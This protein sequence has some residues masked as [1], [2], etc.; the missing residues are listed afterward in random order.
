MKSLYKRQFLLTICL[1]LLSFVLLAAAF[2]SITYRFT[3]RDKQESLEQNAQL[4][5]R[6]TSASILSGGSIYDGDFRM[7]VSF[8]AL[9]SDSGILIAD[10]GGAI[11]LS[12]DGTWTSNQLAGARLP[13]AAVS[14]LTSTGSYTGMT[15]LGGLLGQT[16]YVT[17]A[18]IYRSGSEDL[19]G[20]VFVT[21][22]VSN[23]TELWSSFAR[24]FTVI[25]LAV[26]VLAFLSC[27]LT[28]KWQTKPMQ[29]LA[30]AARRFGRGD[31]AVRVES[32]PQQVDEIRELTEAFNAMADSIERSEARRREFI[33]NI[34]HE[35][36]TP[37]TSI[38]GFTEGILD[39]TIPPE[40]ESAAL[41]TVSDE[42]RRLAR[43]VR[44]MLDVSQLQSS[45]KPTVF[46]PFDL[47]EVM[48]RVLAGLEPKITA[49]HLEMDAALPE[50]PTMVLGEAD[51]ITQ[52]GYNLLDN[53]I[54]FSP[55]GGTIHLDITRREGKAYV[56]VRNTGET[57]A[58]EELAL[59]FDRFHKT[60]RSRSMDREG[61][62]LGLYIAKTII[63]NHRENIEVSSR[64]GVTTFTFSLTCVKKEPSAGRK[65]HAGKS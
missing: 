7:L 16:R 51:A 45:E 2:F 47:A 24:I 20:M 27:S 54:K 28:A 30:Q 9:A 17:G 12:S 44:R 29:E 36:K 52:V 65:E 14:A 4:I 48:R 49:R 40:Q 61:V 22:D 39:G 8:A 35:L 46:E 56:S 6:L 41:T 33:A 32:D 34:S 57:I 21:T 31:F 63:S 25:S 11:V 58:P 26:L 50:L 19:I 55:E 1:V 53:A 38:S 43:L 13:A 10:T 15:T 62:G 59:I 3:L 60:D 18:S 23:L 37:L 64:D 42:T 5:A